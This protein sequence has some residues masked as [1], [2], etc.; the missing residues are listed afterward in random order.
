MKNTSR[1]GNEAERFVCK[2]LEAKGWLVGSRRHTKGAGDHLAVHPEGGG[3]WLVETKAVGPKRSPFTAF[4]RPER[5]AMKATPVPPE[6]KRML[7]VVRGSSP[8]NMQV[9]YI[10]ETAWP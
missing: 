2:D 5:E 3:V 1:R 6:G 8:R 9:E 4:C 7:A 10:S